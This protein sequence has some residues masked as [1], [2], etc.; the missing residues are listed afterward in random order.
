MT[1]RRPKNTTPS[2]PLSS[3]A[4]PSSAHEETTPSSVPA[5]TLDGWGLRLAYIVSFVALFPSLITAPGGVQFGDGTELATAAHVLGVPHPT[6]YPLYMILLFLWSHL[7][8]FLEPIFATTLFNGLCIAL[9]SG[10]TAAIA[11]R[12][13]RELFPQ[14]PDKALVLGSAALG[15]LLPVTRFA[16]GSTLVTE[17]YSLQLLL[18]V[19]VIISALRFLDH[20]TLKRFLILFTLAG[21]GLAH[22]R[23]NLFPAFC[24]FVILVLNLKKLPRNWILSATSLLI[25]APIAI[26][27]YLPIRA[28]A[29][30][31]INWGNTRTI[32]AAIQHARGGDYIGQRFLRPIPGASFT[33]A[34]Y[35]EFALL[36]SGQYLADLATLWGSPIRREMPVFHQPTRRI[37]HLPKNINGWLLSIV[38]LAL[39]CYSTIILLRSGPQSFRIVCLITPVVGGTLLTGYLYNIFDVRDYNLA[40]TWAAALL[41]PLGAAIL[42]HRHLF[43]PRQWSFSPQLGFAFLL[44]PAIIFFGNLPE[45]RQARVLS[46]EAELMASLVLPDDPQVFPQN[47]ILITTG[48]SDIFLAWYQQIVRGIRPDVL[49]FGGNFVASPWYRGFFTPEQIRK[50]Q[51]VLSTSTALGPAEFAQQ[52]RRGIIDENIARFPIFTTTNDP[53][54][55]Q[56]LSATFDLIPVLSAPVRMPTFDE[57]T[58]FTLRQIRRK[59]S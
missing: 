24:A 55:L 45:A 8:G 18:T 3:P 1:K 42:V 30:P 52:L 43:L 41:I 6:G 54:L 59:G 44:A 23:L 35:R 32:A 15:L 46:T 58:T 21:L 11:L 17:V 47:S 27:L 2:A 34:L 50:H 9:T 12:I 20:P 49:I 53:L 37:F 29:N 25:L 28:N 38:T 5:E 14:G 19:A 36:Q 26:H 51:I 57:P 7:L 33:P 22:H 10:L 40:F 16:W 56:E 31:A 4:Q 13:L 39:L 48:D